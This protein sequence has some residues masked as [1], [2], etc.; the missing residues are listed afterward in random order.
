MPNLKEVK[1]RIQSVVS[2]QQITKS[3][4]MVAAAK[5]KKAQ[6]KVINIRP[7]VDRL[8]NLIQR[9]E[10]NLDNKED[11][12]YTKIRAVEK[13]LLVAITSDR[14]L[15]GGFN[16][17]VIKETIR[18]IKDDFPNKKITLLCIGKKGYDIL[19]KQNVETIADFVSIF[20]DLNFNKARET[21]NFIIE[22]FLNKEYDKI[23]L[24]YNES[25]N[26]ATQILKTKNFCP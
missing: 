23:K 13:V 3:M 22:K 17:S 12:V 11:N 26:I 10:S 19:K 15:C 7:Y 1:T 21:A 25:K 16:S 14:G 24:I 9:V 20:Q 18:L 8:T 5:S 2:T 6:D 4:K